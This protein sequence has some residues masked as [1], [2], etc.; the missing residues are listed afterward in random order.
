MCCVMSMQNSVRA[1]VRVCVCV[2]VC[3][4][5]DGWMDGC[6]RC[7]DSAHS[8][9][10]CSNPSRFGSLEDPTVTLVCKYSSVS[11]IQN[12]WVRKGFGFWNSCTVHLYNA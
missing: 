1:C 12:V 11:H 8:D 7:G 4:C 9:A 5:M 3:V 2:C 10:P 6:G